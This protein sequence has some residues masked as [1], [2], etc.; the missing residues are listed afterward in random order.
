MSI[1]T[2]Y[3]CDSCHSEFTLMLGQDQFDEDIKYCPSC[4]E[5][6]DKDLVLNDDKY[7]E[8]WDDPDLQ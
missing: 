5:L 2:E 4:G 3:F 6:L 7:S 8:G 1:T